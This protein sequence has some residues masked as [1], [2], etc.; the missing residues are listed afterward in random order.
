MGDVLYLFERLAYPL[1]VVGAGHGNIERA[2]EYAVVSLNGDAVNLTLEV[3][4]QGI[5]YGIQHAFA[6]H[7]FDA[8]TT[9]E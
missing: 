9:N 7:A 6:V 2:V 1:N 4:M 5:G 8:Q 3:S